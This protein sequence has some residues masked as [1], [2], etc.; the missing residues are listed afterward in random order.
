M[1]IAETERSLEL[2]KQRLSIAKTTYPLNTGEIIDARQDVEALENGIK[3]LNE[4]R[5]E[6]GLN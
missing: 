6:L 2:A 3:Y 5:K 1:D 4:L